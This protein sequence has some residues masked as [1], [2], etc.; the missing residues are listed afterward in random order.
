MRGGQRLVAKQP[1][2]LLLMLQGPPRDALP[3]PGLVSEGRKPPLQLPGQGAG[4]QQARQGQ[5]RGKLGIPR[6]RGL[7]QG[8]PGVRHGGDMAGVFL[9]ESHPPISIFRAFKPQV[10]TLFGGKGVLLP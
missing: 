9:R 4:I 1:G 6:R 10:V 2:L 5:G 3:Q 8:R 7:P